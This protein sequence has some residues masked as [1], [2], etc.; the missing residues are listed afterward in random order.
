LQKKG[1]KDHR[2][3]STREFTV[4]L[5]VLVI[6]EGFTNMTTQYELSK[7]DTHELAKLDVENP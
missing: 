6:S 7:D 2:S 3:Q 5:C 4:R 1:L